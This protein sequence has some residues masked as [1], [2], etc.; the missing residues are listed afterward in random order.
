MK[1]RL[2]TNINRIKKNLWK[3]FDFTEALEKNGYPAGFS[4]KDTLSYDLDRN[5]VILTNKNGDIAMLTIQPDIDEVV[6]QYYQ[7]KISGQ[8]GF[9][10][11]LLELYQH[12][13]FYSDEEYSEIEKI[14]KM[15]ACPANQISKANYEFLEYL[16]EEFNIT[17]GDPIFKNSSIIP[18]PD[19]SSPDDGTLIGIMLQNLDEIPRIIE[20]ELVKL[21]RF[22][23]GHAPSLDTSLKDLI[24]FAKAKNFERVCFR[25]DGANKPVNELPLYD[26]K[27]E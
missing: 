23:G 24:T 12:H 3:V 20:T 18:I 14:T 21:I 9:I 17:P 26:W 6:E 2:T 16:L 15:L 19:I 8:S 7:T 5:E 1:Q 22:S 25:L 4:K 10:K 11:D 27:K 13:L